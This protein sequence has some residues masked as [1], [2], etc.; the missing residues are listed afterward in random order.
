M[1]MV[2]V[3]RSV[4]HLTVPHRRAGHKKVCYRSTA[5]RVGFKISLTQHRPVV[6]RSSFQFGSFPSKLSVSKRERQV[7]DLSERKADSRFV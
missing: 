7:E 5:R 2:H 4:S 3:F 6:D 1:R